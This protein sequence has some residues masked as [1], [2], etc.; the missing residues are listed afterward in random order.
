MTTA[1]ELARLERIDDL[2]SVWENEAQDFTR[3]LGRPENLVL[4]ADTLGIGELETVAEEQ[5]VGQFRAD[6]LCRDGDDS[7]VLIENQI[8]RTD[9]THLGQLLTYAAGLQTASIIWVASE[10]RDE[11][12][13][14]LDWLNEITDERFRFFGLEIEL[15]RI[16][17][18]P[19]APKFNI[20]SRPNGW[21][22]S[23]H[24]VAAVQ[25]QASN[26][27]HQR[28]WARFC[29]YLSE[30]DSPIKPPTTLYKPFITYT[31]GKGGFSIDA[32]RSMRYKRTW[33]DLRISALERLAYFE[34][35]LETREDIE[36]E[37]G[38][39]LDWIEDPDGKVSRIRSAHD[40]DPTNEEDWDRQVKWLDET[41]QAFLR[42]FPQLVRELGG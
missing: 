11:H 30:I 40:T 14:A 9:H 21:T 4:L 20:V 15:W 18:S 35:L 12:R 1:N 5:A 19:A 29:E 33:V 37:I 41:L 39:P 10:F 13:A 27:L 26:P 31:I 25:V 34:L 36:S 38:R 23:A 7:L 6:I 3:W 17:N 32:Y 28:F 22:R 16:A 42:L 2:R 24:H 8:Q